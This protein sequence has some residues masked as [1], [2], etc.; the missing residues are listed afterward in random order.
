VG[1]LLRK[2]DYATMPAYRRSSPE[3]P[4]RSYLCCDQGE[5]GLR[6]RIDGALMSSVFLI[7]GALRT[8]INVMMTCRVVIPADGIPTE[9]CD[10][11]IY[12]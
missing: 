11:S 3:G 2:G 8:S 12:G 1:L 7:L 10:I 5:Y 4:R 6:T 9:R